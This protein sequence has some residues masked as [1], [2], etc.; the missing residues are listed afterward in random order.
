MNTGAERKKK[1]TANY[2]PESS[3][4]KFRVFLT[5]NKNMKQKE[6]LLTVYSRN[7]SYAFPLHN[8]YTTHLTSVINIDL[9]TMTKATVPCTSVLSSEI[10]KCIPLFQFQFQFSL[11]LVFM[12]QFA[13]LHMYASA[14]QKY[15]FKVK[16]CL[17]KHLQ[18]IRTQTKAI[19]PLCLEGKMY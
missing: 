11:E 13:V 6:Y 14:V 7:I 1:H 5:S 18:E 19:S 4:S 9:S 17:K 2:M 3:S 12:K 16:P 8:T 15:S 10:I